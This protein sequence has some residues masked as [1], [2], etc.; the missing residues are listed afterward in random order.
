MEETKKAS[1]AQRLLQSLEK[2]SIFQSWQQTHQNSIAS[3]FF[4]QINHE[5][6]STSQ[7]DIGFYDQ[8]SKKVTVFT[9]NDAGNFEIKATDDVFATNANK[10]EQLKLTKDTLDFPLIIP[11]ALKV[12]KDE[13]PNLQTILG[14]GF[15]ILQTINN[16]TIW[17]IS[18]ITK[19]L[20][21][22]NLK[23]DAETGV[24]V[25]SSNESAMLPD[26]QQAKDN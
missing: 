14:N 19:Q 1:A 2:S 15:V 22:L 3:H 12:I 23:L 13:Y 5:F 18:L 6:N 21:F 9:L 11:P 7:W 25:A 20:T 26:T 8:E 17:N 16:Q 24:K 10:V 4:M